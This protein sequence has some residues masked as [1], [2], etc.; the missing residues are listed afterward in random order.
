M[1][2]WSRTPTTLSFLWSGR[3]NK[4]INYYFNEI[5]AVLIMANWRDGI[6]RRL[7]GTANI[8]RRHFEMR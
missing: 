2:Y 1:F 4:A 3:K 6:P 8:D 7:F 5:R